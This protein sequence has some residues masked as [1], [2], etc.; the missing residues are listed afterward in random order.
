[1]KKIYTDLDQLPAIFGPEELCSIMAISRGLAYAL[2][3]Q[4][5]FPVI[6]IGRRRLIRKDR[7]LAWL[8]QQDVENLY[9]YADP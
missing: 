2:T 6:V 8:D 9:C 3:H 5:G 4:E 1:M 7:F